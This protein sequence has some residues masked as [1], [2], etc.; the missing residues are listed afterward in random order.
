MSR[1]YLV[2][3]SVVKP[4]KGRVDTATL[5]TEF[6]T[7]DAANS[8]IMRYAEAWRKEAT[9]LLHRPGQSVVFFKGYYWEFTRVPAPI[10]NY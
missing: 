1:K 2:E 7:A 9:S 4:N 6:D 3:K 5:P 8:A 10:P